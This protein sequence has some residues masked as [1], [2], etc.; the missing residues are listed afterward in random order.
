MNRRLTVALAAAAS[1]GVLAPAASAAPK[2]NE[3]RISGGPVFKSTNDGITWSRLGGSLRTTD[4]GRS[5][6][7]TAPT[8][9]DRVYAVTTSTRPDN[10]GNLYMELEDM[11]HSGAW[12]PSSYDSTF[13]EARDGR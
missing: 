9:G 4:N 6:V 8:D 13:W 10:W 1:L 2:Q 12:P 11:T 3:I 7:A 5:T